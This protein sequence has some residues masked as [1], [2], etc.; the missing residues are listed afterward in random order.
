[1]KTFVLTALVVLSLTCLTT[2][3]D[4]CQSDGHQCYL[5]EAKAIAAA[6]KICCYDTCCDGAHQMSTNC[7]GPGPTHTACTDA[8]MQKTTMAMN[9]S[10]HNHHMTTAD[11]GHNHDHMTTEDPHAHHM[12][13]DD[14]DDGV[15]NGQAGTSTD[16][17]LFTLYTSKASAEAA[18]T[19]LGCEGSHAMGDKWMP[20]DSHA[21]ECG[22]CSIE[23]GQHNMA[24][25][26][27]E[28]AG[29]ILFSSWKATDAKSYWG[30]I[31][32][33]FLLGVAHEFIKHVLRPT[34]VRKGMKED[35]SEVVLTSMEMTVDGTPVK[36]TQ[37]KKKNKKQSRLSVTHILESALFGIQLVIGYFLMLIAM[38][39]N[40]GLFASVILGLFFGYLVFAEPRTNY[41]VEE[42]DEGCC[43]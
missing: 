13:G 26:S 30:S 31:V 16:C 35:D 11:S 19:L 8:E 36:S 23:G 38:V 12:T 21:N 3:A 24:F 25:V 10:G 7:W 14:D 9:G 28:T 17:S 5:T 1:M 6:K 20:G 2:L 41:D 32:I 40:A 27:R 37:Q 42:E 29:E 39:Y 43:D 34:V 33:V 18:A 22:A 4:E 15:A